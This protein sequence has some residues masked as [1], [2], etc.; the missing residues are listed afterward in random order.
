MRSSKEV[1]RDR[2]VQLLLGKLL[3]NGLHTLRPV[4]NPKHG[5]RYPLVEETVG[6]NHE[7]VDD[8]LKR[9]VE[10]GVLESKVCGRVVLCPNCLSANNK[11]VYQ[12]PRCGSANVQKTELIKHVR[13]GFEEVAEHFRTKVGR[14]VCPSCHQELVEGEYVKHT[15]WLCGDCNYLFELPTLQYL[16]LSCGR[17][18]TPGEAVH[19]NVYCYHL[20]REAVKAASSWVLI[21][22]IVELLR[23]RGYEVESPGFLNG[24]SGTR[25]QFDIVAHRNGIIRSSIAIDVVISNSMVDERYVITT[26]A[27]TFDAHPNESILIAIPG[28]NDAGRRLADTYQI[29]VVEAKNAKEAINKLLRVRSITSSEFGAFD[30]LTLLSLPDHL[31]KTAMAI[32][33][34]G[35]ATASE[36]A[37][38]TGRA[39]AV[40]SDYLNQLVAAGYIKKK[41]VGRKVYFYVENQFG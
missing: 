19:R 36:V 8:F 29:T 26:F 31:R 35:M 25:H 13:C 14:L 11:I 12:C 5:Y 2:R 17:G 16:C 9:L 3:I 15:I 23:E 38:E 41:R 10:D 24:R 40:E 4:F 33:K 21:S 7:A 6:G 39:R 28:L 20:S 34:L 30:V 37:K 18:F 22:P 1:Y 32:C 27:K